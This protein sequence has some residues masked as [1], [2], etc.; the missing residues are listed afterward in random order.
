MKW[1]KENTFL[2]MSKDMKYK[3]SL[4]TVGGLLE[5]AGLSYSKIRFYMQPE[6]PFSDPAEA[7]AHAGR[8]V[9]SFPWLKAY[10]VVRA[11][12]PGESEKVRLFTNLSEFGGPEGQ[13]GS[14]E[15]VLF[16]QK[17]TN[18]L[19]PRELAVGLN[20]H[21]AAQA[22][23]TADS[24]STTESACF[25]REAP[26]YPGNYFENMVVITRNAGASLFRVVLRL[27]VDRQGNL[28]IHFTR[29]EELF[30][31]QM[32]TLTD[33]RYVEA[34][35]VEELEEAQLCGQRADRELER[36]NQELKAL[37]L[38][39]QF[40]R[41]LSPTK[42]GCSVKQAFN[43]A[44][45][46]TGFEFLDSRNFCFKAQ[47]KSGHG[48]V[49]R[50]SIDYGGHIWHRHTF[51][52]EVSGINFDRQLLRVDG[53][54]PQSQEECRM[55]LENLRAQ[56]MF[57]QERAEPVLLEHYGETPSWYQVYHK[58]V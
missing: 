48:Y 34:L 5:Q 7:E 21:C 37:T 47:M 49:Y 27:E 6:W 32:G 17:L 11:G 56:T 54:S 19:C 16:M 26:G 20:V 12:E 3:D 22:G 8:L 50:I 39:H 24:G 42:K 58:Y 30:Q 23:A 28:S 57:L 40:S 36:L 52:L 44:F 31:E 9:R 14:E 25:S 38:P 45:K 15:M 35:A 4:E 10:E 13:P 1:Y 18:A 43:R 51:I 41:N 53:L 29:L 55:N 46:G 33:S 2:V